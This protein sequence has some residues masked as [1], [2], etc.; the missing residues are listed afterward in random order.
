MGRRPLM[1]SA[2]STTSTTSAGTAG[3]G[4]PAAGA[5]AFGGAARSRMWEPALCR[6]PCNSHQHQDLGCTRYAY[7]VAC[8]M[9]SAMRNSSLRCLGQ[10]G[11]FSE[12]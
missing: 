2:P 10:Q 12:P 9:H 3:S 5:A 1:L 8:A 4:M 11:A 7:A 6:G